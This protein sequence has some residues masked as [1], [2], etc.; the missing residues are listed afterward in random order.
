MGAAGGREHGAAMATAPFPAPFPDGRRAGAT[1]VAATGAFLLLASATVFVA[2]RWDRL[3]EEAKVALVGAL[4]ATFLIGG[5]ALR[6]SLPATGDVLFHLGALLV[7]IDV[8]ALGLRLDVGWRPL[9]AVEGLVGVGVLGALAAMSGSVVLATAA[10]A[11]VVV[12]A[13]GVAA[14]SPMPAPLVLAVA[15]VVAHLL[16]R[17]R[18]AVAWAAVAGLAPVLGAVTSALVGLTDG[19]TGAGVLE[20][21]GL[22]G[23][24]ASL[25]AVAS[26]TAAAAV[27]GREA[28]RRRDL[29]LVALAGACIT[30]G[31]VTTWVSTEPSGHAT[32]LA[33]SALFVLVQAVALLVGRDPFWGR[34]ARASAVG[35]EIGAAALATPVALGLLLVAP[36]VEDRLDLFGDAPGWSPQPVAAVAWALL[37]GGWLLA[38]WRRHLG[39]VPGRR[40]SASGSTPVGNAGLRPLGALR[41]ALAEPRTVMF[42][43]AA[44]GAAAV[45]GTASTVAIGGV[46]VVLAAALAASRG[47]LAMLVAAAAAVWAP[48][49][50]GLSHPL[51]ALPI[52]LTAA[53]VLGAAGLAWRGTA[54]GWVS[55]ELATAGSLLAFC[56]FAIARDQIGLPASMVGAVTAAWALALLVERA[57]PLA[58]HAARATMLI[59]TMGSLTG[60][61]ADALIVAAVA[62]LL[63]TIDAVR[64]R[65]PLIAVGA[66]LAA[67]VV[68]G[69][70]ALLVG[71]DLAATGVVLC[72]S[73]AVHLGAAALTPARWRLPLVVAAAAA[74]VAGLPLASADAARFAQ[75]LVLTGAVTLVTGLVLRV[76]LVG[77]AGGALAGLGI[78][79]HLLAVGVTVPE[80]FVAPVA[81]QLLVAGCQLRRRATE[82]DRVSSWFAYGP[83][84]ALMGGVALAERLAGGEAWHGLVAGAVGMT[85]VAVGGWRRLAGPLFLGTGLLTVVTVLESVATLAG[86]PTW[87]WLAAGGITL[88]STG[89]ALE[90]SATSPV[91]AG[92]RLVDVVGERFS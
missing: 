3:A 15:A 83:A 16:G 48:L 70:T 18:A 20:E 47:G 85:A 44:V 62:T 17:H 54:G 36:F 22:G 74:L 33:A 66:A 53:G 39:P 77:H 29:A 50:V 81:F 11:S 55:A 51:A 6:R 64:H 28:S 68:V 38:A 80:A 7:P 5:R 46:L 63:F 49:L 58:G 35:A 45:V 4:T 92:R 10:G 90:R 89:V 12:L 73:A 79:L 52:G 86:V 37:A 59:G 69:A 19:R 72:A 8:A 75:A 34:P 26:G 84:I 1:W 40:T 82:G 31:A 27:L 30:T 42:L 41:A 78:G 57:S 56:S 25:V 32:F 91:E 13:G 61:A 23:R 14:L 21:L 43:A 9:V 24:S 87:A 60:S 76:G 67:Q 65:E 71:V 88:L 2:V